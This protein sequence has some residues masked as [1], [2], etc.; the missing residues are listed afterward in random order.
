M[1]STP[2]TVLNEEEE[3]KRVGFVFEFGAVSFLFLPMDK[4]IL[5]FYL[6]SLS[7][8]AGWFRDQRSP[9]AANECLYSCLHLVGKNLKTIA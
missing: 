3:E 1:L 2:L 8:G 7:L 4:F 5:I 9:T 6:N